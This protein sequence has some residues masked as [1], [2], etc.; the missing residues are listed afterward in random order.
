M[1]ARL[2][3]RVQ[4]FVDPWTVARQ[5]PLSMEFSSQEYWRGL[6]STPPGDLLDPGFKLVSHVSPALAGRFFITSTT[7]EAPEVKNVHV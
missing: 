1:C 5:T 6:S 2:L 3:S 4:L 7:W